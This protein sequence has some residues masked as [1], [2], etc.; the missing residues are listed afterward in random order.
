MLVRGLEFQALQYWEVVPHCSCWSYGCS[1]NHIHGVPQL[2]PHMECCPQEQAGCQVGHLL[3]ECGKL[4]GECGNICWV[5]WYLALLD[6][7]WL[8]SLW[9]SICS[10]LLNVLSLLMMFVVLWYPAWPAVVVPKMRQ[11]LYVTTKWFS[12]MSQVLVMGDKAFHSVTRAW[13]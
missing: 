11:R 6:T 2:Q 12:N 9:F 4:L 10:M 1:H 8:D 7:C 13:L 3:E 5:D